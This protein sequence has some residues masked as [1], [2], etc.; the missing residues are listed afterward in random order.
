[1][2]GDLALGQECAGALEPGL[3]HRE[4][5]AHQARHMERSA[6]KN[7]A[8]CPRASSRRE[9]E[10]FCRIDAPPSAGRRARSQARSTYSC[11]DPATNPGNPAAVSRL[12]PTRPAWTCPRRL[13]T[14]TPIHRASQ[15][16]AVP[17]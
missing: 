7:R 8:A 1:G 5:S 14:G 3:A 13:T 2:L 16:V 6:S 9:V 10:S 11:S 15:V 4:P 12:A 17:L